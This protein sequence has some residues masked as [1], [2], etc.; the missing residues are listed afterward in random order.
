MNTCHGYFHFR[1]IVSIYLLLLFVYHITLISVIFSVYHF[2]SCITRFLHFIYSVLLIFHMKLCVYDSFNYNAFFLLRRIV[3]VS[4]IFNKNRIWYRSLMVSLFSS[5][6]TYAFHT[7]IY[8]YLYQ[9]DAFL[10]I[11]IVVRFIVF[12]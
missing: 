5:M 9:H 8:R 10:N 4:L 12:K 2:T 3:S 6:S 11:P 1:L 7:L